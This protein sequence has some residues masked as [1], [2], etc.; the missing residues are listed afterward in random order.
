MNVETPQ[1]SAAWRESCKKQLYLRYVHGWYLKVCVYYSLCMQDVS[2][3]HC[4]AIFSQASFPKRVWDLAVEAMDLFQQAKL[5]GQK[6]NL[7]TLLTKPEFKQQYF[8]PIRRLAEDEQSYLLRKVYK[9][10][11]SVSV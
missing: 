7:S 4:D 6:L 8:A 2:N 5:K 9:Y 3:T 10:M 1:P 11:H